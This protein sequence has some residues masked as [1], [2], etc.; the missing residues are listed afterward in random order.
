VLDDTLQPPPKPWQHF[1]KQ[2]DDHNATIRA[3]DDIED[4]LDLSG[5]E[6]LRKLELR[7][8]QFQGSASAKFEGHLRMITLLDGAQ[9]FYPSRNEFD[10]LK[11]MVYGMFGSALLVGS[12]AVAFI[13]AQAQ[14]LSS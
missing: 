13:L 1:R 8:S 12:L 2:V 4:D 9:S 14:R 5:V 3:S 7:F 6:R 11:F 10:N